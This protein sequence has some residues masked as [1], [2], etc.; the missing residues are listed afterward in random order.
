MQSCV[1][2]MIDLKPTLSI[3]PSKVY[4]LSDGLLKLIHND[5]IDEEYRCIVMEG[6]NYA[7]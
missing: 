1:N 5:M 7:P 2:A 6:I 3:D 4:I